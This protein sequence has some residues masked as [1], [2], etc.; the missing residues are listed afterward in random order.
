MASNLIKQV[1]KL[2]GMSQDDAICLCLSIA[3]VIGV[4]G[5]LLSNDATAARAVRSVIRRKDFKAAIKSG[6]SLSELKEL[7][8]P[9]TRVLEAS[10]PILKT[11]TV[12]ISRVGLGKG[13]HMTI[14]S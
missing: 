9:I 8:K 12:K 3:G 1:T 14:Y 13:A 11:S 10:Y 4:K 5:P 7:A 6:K 2:F